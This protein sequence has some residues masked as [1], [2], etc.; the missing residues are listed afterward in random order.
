MN[1]KPH[2]WYEPVGFESHL[3]IT[4]L[5]N[6]MLIRKILREQKCQELIIQFT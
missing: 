1:Q 4:V 3:L 2:T 6:L 5:E